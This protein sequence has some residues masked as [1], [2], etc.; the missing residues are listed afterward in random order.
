MERI[1]ILSPSDVAKSQKKE[2]ST[3]ELWKKNHNG[4]SLT[5]IKSVDIIFKVETFSAFVNYFI[6]I[7]E[8]IKTASYVLH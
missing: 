1:A 5:E 8:S 7:Y 6:V 4:I 3:P 2:L